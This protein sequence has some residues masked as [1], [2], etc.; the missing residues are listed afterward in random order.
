MARRKLNRKEWFIRAKQQA[1]K[2]YA[3]FTKGKP[4]DC[5]MWEASTT[6]DGYGRFNI[7]GRPPEVVGGS[8]EGKQEGAHRFA[9]QFANDQPVPD[10][11][12]ILHKCDTP[13]C[14]N[15]NHLYAGTHAQ[16]QRKLSGV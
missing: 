13:G 5:W 8:K 6:E 10:G 4:A 14:V 3:K 1:H 15:H 11:L 9:W 7:Y 2:F 16:N 12:H